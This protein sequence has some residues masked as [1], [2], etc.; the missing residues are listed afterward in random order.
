MPKY[1]VQVTAYC[2]VFIEADSAE[3]AA[4]RACD[5]INYGDFEM[6]TGNEAI[7]LKTEEEISSYR[8]H[9]NAWI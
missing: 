7:E 6:D 8:R 2:D 3:E 5:E 4:E 9:A 1:S